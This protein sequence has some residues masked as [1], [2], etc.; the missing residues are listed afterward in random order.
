[1]EYIP[2]V[3]VNGFVVGSIYALGALGFTLI[4]RTNRFMHLAHSAVMMSG[5]YTFFSIFKHSNLGFLISSSLTIVFTAFIGLLIYRLVYKPLLDRKASLSVMLLTSLVLKFILENIIM[6]I[7][8][9][10]FKHTPHV[11]GFE[12]Y[13]IF[14]VNITPIELMI[15]LA[16]FLMFIL[17]YLLIQKTTLGVIFRTLSDNLELAKIRGINIEK[18]YNYS[19]IISSAI[20][21]YAAILIALNQNFSPD[22]SQMIMAKIFTASL[23]G[24]LTFLPGAVLGGYFLGISENLVLFWLP[25][26][27][28]DLYVFLLLFLLLIIRPQ[29]ILYYKN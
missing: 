20:A 19:F 7:F 17:V 26:G 22:L 21:G 2:Q 23:I 5:A 29:G 8:G 15:I 16:S 1:M 11:F 27:F 9:P 12:S 3:I 10:V 24:G 6:L 28:K 18:Y 4:A 14:S 25:I 13:K